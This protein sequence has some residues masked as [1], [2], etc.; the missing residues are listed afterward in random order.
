MKTTAK[1]EQIAESPQIPTDVP[2]KEGMTAELITK[3]K[4]NIERAC[5]LVVM[6]QSPVVYDI[7]LFTEWCTSHCWHHLYTVFR[8]IVAEQQ[9]RHRNVFEKKKP[10]F[11]HLRLFC[12]LHPTHLKNSWFERTLSFVIVKTLEI[13][14]KSFFFFRMCTY[15]RFGSNGH[16]SSWS[17]II[18]FIDRL[19]MD[20]ICRK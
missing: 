8:L 11:L 6:F 20:G 7:I 17:N 19:Q 16:D 15:S 14:R 3:R 13:V 12:E 10:F 5:W 1:V 2:L 18:R 4:T 9:T